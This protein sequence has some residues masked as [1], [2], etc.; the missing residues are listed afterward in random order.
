MF[1]CDAL[2]GGVVG[3]G[4]EIEYPHIVMFC[5]CQGLFHIGEQVGIDLQWY[6]VVV[7]C[8]VGQCVQGIEFFGELMFFFDY[9]G[10]LFVQQFVGV[11]E[12]FVGQ[13]VQ[14]IE[15]FGEL[16]FF[17]DY[18][19]VLFVQQFVG[20]GEDF[21]VVVVDDEQVGIDLQWY[22]VVVECFVGQC[23]QGIEMLV[24]KFYK[25]WKL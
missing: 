22:V 3:N 8:F 12:D 17:F 24:C 2:L 11:G 20:V 21:V 5:C 6:V 14:G 9:V 25:D 7:E 13:C 19:G 10:V 16:M 15:F 4:A 23:V 1:Q 18:V